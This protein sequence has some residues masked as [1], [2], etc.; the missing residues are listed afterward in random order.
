[1]ADLIELLIRL[2][3]DKDVINSLEKVE[4]LK[5]AL[6]KEKINLQIEKNKDLDKEIVRV[7]QQIH[8]L[9]ELAKAGLISD[10][11]KDRLK[12]LQSELD[13]L[14]IRAADSSAQIGEITNGI[15]AATNV[16]KDLVEEAKQ[17]A[18]AEAE[19]A[20]QTNAMAD[21]AA[22][23]E[24]RYQAVLN[25]IDGISSALSGAASGVGLVNDFASG[26]FSTFGNVGDMFSFSILDKALDTITS[27]ITQN[28]TGNLDRIASRYDIMS[29]FDQ[30]M[31]LMGIPQAD[32]SNSLSRLNESI[33]GLPIGLDE[34][35]YR[36][37]R[38]QMFIG[39]IDKA[40]DFTIGIQRAIMA[41]GA[42]E[43][44][45]N[46][47]Y[48][49]IERLLTTGELTNKRQWMSLLNGL[50]VSVQFI[51]EELG[52]A[53]M[54]G[55]E[56]AAALYTGKISTDEFLGAITSLGRG[57]SAAAQRLNSALDI[58]KGTLESWASNIEFAFIRGGTNTLDAINR[59]LVVETD[60]SVVGYM[61]KFRDAVN[62]AF[63]EMQ[64]WI[65]ENPD[66][67]VINFEAL[68]NLKDSLSRFSIGDI[69]EEALE[70]TAGFINAIATALNNFDADKTESFIAFGISIAKPLATIGKYA[71]ELGVAMG[72][73]ERFEGHDWSN[74]F[75]K[76]SEN[77]ND[78]SNITSGL[79]N[80][81]PDEL[82]DELLA[83]GLTDGIVIYT[84]LTWMSK[85]F[86]ALHSA[87]EWFADH[88]GWSTFGQLGIAI[89]LVA[90][91]IA[92][93]NSVKAEM[94]TKYNFADLEKAISDSQA[95]RENIH[96]IY[97][98]F[99]DELSKIGSQSEKAEE[100]LNKIGALDDAVARG[101]ASAV[102]K[103]QTTVE[104]WNRLFPEISLTI[105]ENTRQLDENSRAVTENAES[106]AKA[107]ER[108]RTVNAY[109][110]YLTDL[111]KAQIDLNGQI[112][113][114]ERALDSARKNN[115]EQW[116]DEWG[117]IQ[118]N[119]LL[120][121][122]NYLLPDWDLLHMGSG[123][124]EAE[125]NKLLDELEQAK[126][127]GK[128]LEDQYNAA[129]EALNGLLTAED[130]TAKAAEEVVQAQQD[131]ASGSNQV[132]NALQEQA[133]A[134]DALTEKYKGYAT[135][136]YDSMRSA[137][138]AFNEI[139]PKDKDYDFNFVLKNNAEKMV[140]VQQAGQV[141]MDEVAKAITSGGETDMLLEYVSDLF[142]SQNYDAIIAAA[143]NASAGNIMSD[144]ETY[145]KGLSAIGP[146]SQMSALMQSLNDDFATTMV[147]VFAGEIPVWGEAWS[148]L[149]DQYNSEMQ[150][151]VD[152]YGYDPETG[153][154]LNV[155]TSNFETAMQ[156]LD[157]FTHKYFGNGEDSEDDTATAAFSYLQE[158]IAEMSET[159]LPENSDAYEALGIAVNAFNNDALTP[160]T[161]QQADAAQ[162][163]ENHKTKMN[164][165]SIEASNDISTLNEYASAVNSVEGALNAA[166]TAAGNLASAL[167][168]IPTVAPSFEIPS[169]PSVAPS[170]APSFFASGGPVDGVFKGGDSVPAFL[171]PGEFVVRRKVAQALGKNFLQ[172]LNNM[173]IPAAV[174][175]LMRG[176]NIP[177]GHGIVAYDNRRYNDNHATINQNIVTNNPAFTYRRASRFVGAL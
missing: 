41:G 144:V 95:I 110:D 44:M 168:S 98:D 36:L 163:T 125:V 53:D 72:V 87:I 123:F 172:H 141:L 29:T 24:E 116:L 176:V 153:A 13:Q 50:G 77:I 51:A 105:D 146:S 32:A 112:A 9:Q 101:D 136:A 17:Q 160:L 132:T 18:Q 74:L 130:E 21:A 71:G 104:Q 80:M 119:P 40:T 97:K 137:V 170:V 6:Q 75:S 93:Y 159:T 35:A 86:N 11:D 48:N 57:T 5:K 167:S 20:A 70:N 100:L 89:G 19:A 37:R 49:Q 55:K 150:S 121:F 1:M 174:E 56:L 114:I 133:D 58:Y 151:L 85:G 43:Q 54:N 15:N 166:A 42:N 115:T 177:M 106:Y 152:A 68:T 131:V 149:F 113:I 126:A 88:G 2:S 4:N 107:L 52:H 81:I 46:M 63:A 157:D 173:N 82:M 16:S 66:S 47:S 147:G 139:K 38:Y 158:L 138:A 145:A 64:Q 27:M 23:A 31:A 127:E 109:Q 154:F 60:V 135:T 73:V 122:I 8:D 12:A 61:E 76:I 143:A 59:M 111:Q 94:D 161:Q 165:L 83:F 162:E 22:R 117:N 10:A 14:R 171:T 129:E 175:S 84:G 62:V 3:G 79:L 169:I 103:L 33:L 108:I 7:R 128:I 96:D 90:G 148:A 102:S 92:Y 30:Y 65:D 34:A 69:A 118:R 39:D 67:F 78:I 134:L 99:D 142:A 28:I 155:D 156:A 140:E 164:E 91:A 25:V 26:I 124:T 120:H 45:R